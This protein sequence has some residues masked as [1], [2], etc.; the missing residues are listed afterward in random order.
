MKRAKRTH[1]CN[2][3]DFGVCVYIVCVRKIAV[4]YVFPFYGELQRITCEGE[5]K[6][7]LHLVGLVRPFTRLP[8]ARIASMVD[9]KQSSKT[10]L[11]LKG[12][13]L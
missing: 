8:P 6:L 2:F 13:R 7:L 4:Y 10:F 12:G 9:T 11:F 1:C 3:I 5:Q